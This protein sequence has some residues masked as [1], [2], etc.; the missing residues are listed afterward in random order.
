MVLQT[1]L[2]PDYLSQPLLQPGCR[3]ESQDIGKVAVAMIQSDL[4][5]RAGGTLSPSL[6]V[7]WV[8]VWAVAPGTV[9]AAPSHYCQGKAAVA[10][11]YC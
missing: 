9:S 7:M 10:D 1:R 6:A 4:G 11:A 5:G 3:A 8:S 2:D